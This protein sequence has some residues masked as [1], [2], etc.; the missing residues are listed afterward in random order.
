MTELVAKNF[1][2]KVANLLLEGGC[3]LGEWGHTSAAEHKAIAEP[4]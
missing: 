4:V 2:K 3:N 1:L